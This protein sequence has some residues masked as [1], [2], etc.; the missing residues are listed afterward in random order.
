MYIKTKNSHLLPLIIAMNGGLMLM[1]IALFYAFGFGILLSC[2][3]LLGFALTGLACWKVIDQP[4]LAKLAV[5]G[6]SASIS[7][8]VLCTIW[9]WDIG[10]ASSSPL[11]TKTASSLAVLAFAL[12]VI[13]L[14]LRNPSPARYAKICLRVTLLLIA[15]SSFYTF[16]VIWLSLIQ[17]DFCYLL[18][19][20]LAFLTLLSSV[21]TPLLK[22]QLTQLSR[23]RWRPATLPRR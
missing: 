10:S 4:Q 8:A 2:L 17:N 11:C 3:V 5:L 7:G 22:K 13:A 16:A 18:L 12:A 15:A 1:F 6:M 20:A 23:P 19:C 14:L 21:L 9:I